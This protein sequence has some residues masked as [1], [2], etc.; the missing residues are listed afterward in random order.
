VQLGLVNI[1]ESTDVPLGL[2][3]IMTDEPLRF[4]GHTS[5]SGFTTV[6]ILHGGKRVRYLY[7]AGFKAFGETR[8]YGAGLGLSLHFPVGRFFIDPELIAMQVSEDTIERT[9]F[10]AM[11]RL[12]LGW[13]FSARFALF[14]APSVTLLS[15]GGE[16][17]LGLVPG[18]S[19]PTRAARGEPTIWLYPDLHLGFR[20]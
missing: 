17:G 10:L 3:N 1:S 20:F 18:F 4:A 16:D 15:T 11:A 7:L 14:L 19:D 5:A 8:L 12:A 6:G 13:R 2:V 9:S